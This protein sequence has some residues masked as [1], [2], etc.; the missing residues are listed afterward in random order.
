M[1]RPATYNLTIYQR[2]TFRQ[3]F[4]I[5][6]DFTD[7]EVCAQVWRTRPSA[8]GGGPGTSVGLTQG[9]ERDYKKLDFTVEFIDRALVE[10][11]ITKGVFE[12]IAT[13]EQTAVLKVGDRL[14]WDLLVVDGTTLLN[15]ERAY[16]LHGSV[17]LDPG[18]SDCGGNE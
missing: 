5:P 15:G 10:D 17:N 16:W 6:L 8:G 3:R 18:L 4:K 1:L 2:A 12:L 9:Y 13:A 7:R 14:E 11:G